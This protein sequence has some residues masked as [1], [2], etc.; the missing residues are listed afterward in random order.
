MA[1]TKTRALR[2][3]FLG[4][5]GKGGML[6]SVTD[7]VTSDKSLCL[8]LRGT[9]INVYYRGGSLMKISSSRSPMTYSLDFNKNYFKGGIVP[10]L[11]DSKINSKD[12]I[13]R[14]IEIAPILK[15]SM[16]QHSRRREER[17]F[18]QIILRDNNFGSSAL[19]TDYYICDIEYAS[20]C[21]Q[22]DMIAVHWPSNGATRKVANDR[23][24]AFIE[25]K[26]GDN[27][28][29]NKSGL[30]AHI[31]D[32]NKF[33]GDSNNLNMI[34]QEMVDVFNQKRRL[35][36]ITCNKDLRSFSDENPLLLL[37]LVNHDPD[38]TTLRDVLNNLPESPHVD[39]H[40]ATAS[41]LGYGLCNQGI[42][43]LNDAMARFGEYIGSR[44]L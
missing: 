27:A 35:G 44:R 20:E 13:E 24:I 33:A 23:R 36:L 25:V 2:S 42:H 30:S 1:K 4:D 16:D 28:L 40:I 18:Q 38:S 17:E 29:M 32:I 43:P 6:C 5:L 31:E 41:F 11:P 39:L 26:Y 34:K 19:Q 15:R 10:F 3:E 21:G 14:W 12:D 7:M 37:A 8:E 22:Y 9:S